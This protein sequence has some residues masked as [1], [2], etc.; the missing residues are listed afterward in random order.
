M[1]D[2]LVPYMG[3]RTFLPF[4]RERPDTTR[5]EKAAA[6]AAGGG[7]STPKTPAAAPAPKPAAAPAPAAAAAPKAAAAP[8]PAAAAPAPKPAPAKAAPSA[9]APAAAAPAPAPPAPKP[10]AAAAAPL[11]ISGLAEGFSAAVLGIVGRPALSSAPGLDA[12][13]ASLGRVSYV[14]GHVP[15]A[16]D[17]AVAAALAAAGV[18]PA[19]EALA[20]RPHV[21]R[22]LRHVGSFTAEQRAAWPITHAQA[23]SG[24]VDARKSTLFA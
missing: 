16:E 18:T 14:A 11:Q 1:P 17:E 2:V 5:K 12:L 9:A 21:A 4:V 6:A 13:N 24:A 3:G 23:L 8:A 15:S 19:A 10:A 7:A 22:W 20:T